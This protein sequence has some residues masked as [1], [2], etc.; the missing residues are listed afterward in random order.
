MKIMNSLF[1][2][3]T[4][5][6][7][8]LSYDNL[9]S[10]LSTSRLR[11]AIS[12]RRNDPLSKVFIHIS[13]DVEQTMLSTSSRSSKKGFFGVGIDTRKQLRIL[14]GLDAEVDITED[15]L[16]ISLPENYNDSIRYDYMEHFSILY[17]T[18]R[19]SA[20]L[21]ICLRSIRNETAKE[22]NL[23]R[24]NMMKSVPIL[25]K[26]LASRILDA[27]SPFNTE[28]DESRGLYKFRPVIS[29]KDLPPELVK[30][31]QLSE[32][33]Y[34]SEDLIAI[35]RSN[36]AA[37]Y[38]AEIKAYEIPI[39]INEVIMRDIEWDNLTA[40]Q[41]SKIFSY[42][43][44]VYIYI[45]PWYFERVNAEDYQNRLVASITA[46]KITFSPRNQSGI[47]LYFSQ[48]PEAVDEEG[49]GKYSILQEDFGDGLR[50]YIR[51]HEDREW[52]YPAW[53]GAD[54]GFRTL[55]DAQEW[56]SKHDWK[57]ATSQNID[58][59]E[60][61]TNNHLSE[62]KDAMELLGFTKSSSEF[63]GKDNNV[64]ELSLELDKKDKFG[65]KQILGIRCM[66]FDEEISVDYWINGKRIPASSKPSNTLNI[67]K[68]IRNIENMLKKYDYNIFSNCI[69]TRS[70]NRSSIM[71]AIN[72]KNVASKMVRVKSSNIWS[73]GINVRNYG[74][75]LGDVVVQF[76]EKNGGPGA[77]YIYYDVPVKVYRRWQSAPSKGHYFW[78]YIRNIYKYSKLTGDKRGKLKNAIN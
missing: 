53:I 46:S 39:K 71:S 14:N 68:T 25:R 32:K 1:D 15:E 51:I 38:N 27:L 8:T 42:G 66:Y 10:I 24:N 2:G 65:G 36:S 60:E 43:Y 23:P 63:Y 57:N 69:I 56:L 7:L 78:R 21:T 50:F 12:T 48:N 30:E 47:K 6:H 37:K 55:R 18:E 5:W 9:I 67:A 64:Y 72:T 35:K 74:D 4:F 75:K 76:K 22:L 29:D 70:G 3:P 59:D 28:Y 11:E 54:S 58:I 26:A 13:N 41:K 45:S 17:Y 31:I 77:I 19:G 52:K 62:F 20:P 34:E 16:K 49:Y 44:P 73:Y 33:L 61:Y 40:N